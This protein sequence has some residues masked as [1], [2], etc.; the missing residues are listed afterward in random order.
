MS[1]ENYILADFDDH[2]KGSP[3]DKI[4]TNLKVNRKASYTK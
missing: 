2:T 1:T 3:F 4:P